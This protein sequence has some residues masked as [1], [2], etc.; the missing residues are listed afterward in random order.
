MNE[1]SRETAK[2]VSQFSGIAVL[3]VIGY[4]CHGM[5]RFSM[6]TL[7]SIFGYGLYALPFLAIRPVRRLRQR[8]RVWGWIVLAP[9][10]L[11]SSFLLLGKALFEGLLGVTEHTR[12]LQTLQVGSSTVELQDYDYGGGVGVH[13]LNL[14]QRRIV[15]TGL[16]LVKSVAFFDSAREGTLTEE[17]AYAVRVHAKGSY[18]SNDYPIDKIYHLKRWVYF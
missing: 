3:L 9:L 4:G 14:E 7:N 17:G 10:L 8:P 1:S 13:G 2:A 12:T 5:L 16:Y 15:V 18:A 11:L 6:H